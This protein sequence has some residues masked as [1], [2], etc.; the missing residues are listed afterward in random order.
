MS[1]YSEHW[2]KIMK[3]LIESLSYDKSLNSKRQ[4][5]KMV[6]HTQKICLLPA[7]CF[8]VFDDYVGLAPKKYLP[9]S[10]FGKY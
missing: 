5:H 1:I 6:K 10:F 3:V 2:P 7:N 4:P 8:N 9:K